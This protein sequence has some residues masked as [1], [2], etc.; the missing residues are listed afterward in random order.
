MRDKFTV[1]YSQL[2]STHWIANIIQSQQWQLIAMYFIK[3]WY[4]LSCLFLGHPCTTNECVCTLS[5][6]V[7][8]DKHQVRMGSSLC[9][10][11][12]QKNLPVLGIYVEL[13]PDPGFRPNLDPDVINSQKLYNS[14]AGKNSYKKH[15]LTKYN[16]IMT[17]PT[18]IKLGPWIGNFFQHLPLIY[19][20]FTCINLDPNT[21]PQSY[22]I[23]IHFDPDPRHWFIQ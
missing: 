4:H 13:N 2:N 22:W 9:N 14:L 21:D 10:S 3:G 17:K 11:M 19:S 20:I 12:H 23:Q 16:K 15:F 1:K 5:S 7:F 6:Q 8:H 18:F